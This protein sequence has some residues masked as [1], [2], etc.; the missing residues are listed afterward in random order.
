MILTFSAAAFYEVK[1]KIYLD[2]LHAFGPI[3]YFNPT[4]LMLNFIIDNLMALAEK[5]LDI[6]Y[7]FIIEINK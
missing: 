2:D 6:R 1:S 7:N 5:S 4:R 3:K